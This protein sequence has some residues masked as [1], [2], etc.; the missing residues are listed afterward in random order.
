MDVEPPKTE[1]DYVEYWVNRQS[2]G[3]GE[4]YPIVAGGDAYTIV[5]GGGGG[6]GGVEEERAWLEVREQAGLMGGQARAMARARHSKTL[7]YFGDMSPSERTIAFTTALMMPARRNTINNNLIQDKEAFT[8]N[9]YKEE[10]WRTRAQL[11][12][13]NDYRTK[14]YWAR[15][16]P[17]RALFDKNY[18]RVGGKSIKVASYTKPELF[19]LAPVHPEPFKEILVTRDATLLMKI[20]PLIEED[21]KL[22]VQLYL[23]QIYNE[24]KVAYFLNELLYAY[25]HVLSIHFMVMVDWFQTSRSELGLYTQATHTLMDDHYSQFTVAEYAEDDIFEFMQNHPTMDALRG[26][27]FHVLPPLETAWL[28]NEFIHYDMHTGNVMMKRTTG[29]DSPLSGRN[30]L[31]KRHGHDEWYQLT[32]ANL[33][34]HIVKIIDFGFSR[35]YAPREPAHK[36]LIDINQGVQRHIH[37]KVV[38]LEWPD[39]DISRDKPNRYADVRMFLLS[40]LRLSPS[41][42]SAIPLEERLAFYAFVEDVIDFR[43]MNQLID[44]APVNIRQERDAHSGGGVLAPDNLLY[45][46]DCFTYLTRFGGYARV[47][48][49]EGYTASQVLDH[50]FFDSLRRAPQSHN[51]NDRGMDDVVV[52]FF[53]SIGEEQMLK[54]LSASISGSTSDVLLCEVCG[55]EAEHYN[56]EEGGQVVPLCGAMCA[57]FK[58]LYGCKTVYR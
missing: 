3:R 52:S 26:V 58:Y 6:G 11:E 17:N 19:L 7:P 35:L 30:L 43:R 5:G 9:P 53:T 18:E 33:G 45:C 38:G 14:E 20:T 28:T 27:I 54:Q 10:T 25:K 51:E 46:E 29:E 56:V 47:F 13:V 44:N 48:E 24:I 21:G 36:R 40:I 8:Q 22:I 57:E 32:D 4:A 39:A 31:Y 50:P 42:W 1:A 55:G 2:G 16:G 23:D 15:A 12:V 34:G 49:G 37:D 41:M